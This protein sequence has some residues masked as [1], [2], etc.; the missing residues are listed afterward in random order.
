M[1]DYP[2]ISVVIPSYNRFNYL[3]ES[4]ESVRLQNYPNIEIII[5]NDGS[6]ESE[7]YQYA[8]GK[9][10]KIIHLDENQKTIH[11]FGPGSIRNF[12]TN[13]ATGD[14]LAFLDDD[15]IWL[16]GKL[17]IQIDQM[18]SRNFLLSST[19]G[20][21]GEGRYDINK[22]YQL[23]NKERYMKDYKYLYKGTN[24]IVNNNLP[25]I[26]SSEFTNIWNCFI[27]SSVVVEKKLF[28]N[29]GSF[30]NLP[31]WA[32][33]DCWKGLQQ[34]TDSLYINEPLFYF[35]GLHGDGRNYEK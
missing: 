32:D 23:Y 17:E 30:R 12:G 27:T 15:D 2:K 29:L 21:Y 24:Y 4:L 16:E 7:Y 34:L 28:Q 9:D 22:S 3:L 8:F 26:W 20:F 5:I 10:T 13:L 18:I 19:E 6:T 11:G 14:Y 25:E 35:D 31:K 1:V 33:Y